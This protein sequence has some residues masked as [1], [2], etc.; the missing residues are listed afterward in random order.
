MP[1]LHEGRTQRIYALPRIVG[2]RPVNSPPANHRHQAT[3]QLGGEEAEPASSGSYHE[4][5]LTP[6]RTGYRRPVT[7]T[8]VTRWHSCSMGIR[9]SAQ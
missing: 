2:N 1:A 5:V 4:R 8:D 7:G 3:P 6:C 9:D